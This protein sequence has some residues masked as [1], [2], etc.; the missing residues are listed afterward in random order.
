[1][2]VKASGARREG[3]GLRAHGKWICHGLLIVFAVGWGRTSAAQLSST[4]ARCRNRIG[5]G[6]S[7]LA[8]TVLKEREKCHKL[9]MRGQLSPNTDCNDP[10]HS[11]VSTKIASATA[12][13][14]AL[15][16]AGCEGVS[17]PQAL[18]YL[19]CPAPCDTVAITDDASVANCLACLTNTWASN[20]VELVYGEPLVSAADDGRTSC[21]NSV[22]QGLRKY[23]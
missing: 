16:L 4:D 12:K 21:Q 22:G 3:A 14:T 18:G 23:L 6:V 7:K 11:P 8:D 1:M 17:S 20:A 10:A 5:K 9:R 13:L 19:Q 15:T 2:Y